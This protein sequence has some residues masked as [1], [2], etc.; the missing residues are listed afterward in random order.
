MR[1]NVDILREID[2]EINAEVYREI[3]FVS[4]SEEDLFS[5]V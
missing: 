2:E 5:M 4:Y 1:K 3:K